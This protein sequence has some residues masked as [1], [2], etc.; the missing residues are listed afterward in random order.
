MDAITYIKE[1]MRMCKSAGD[2]CEHCSA[3]IEKFCPISLCRTTMNNMHGNEEKAVSIVEQWSKD[4][5]VKTRQSEF[6]KMFPNTDLKI[7]TRLLPC[8]LDTTL[9]PL[10]CAKYGYLSISCRCDRCR[11]DYW[12][13]EVTDND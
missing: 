12:L 2:N 11:D 1:A 4:H 5:P 13:T 8:S 3:K 6:L 7:I 10:R 9:K